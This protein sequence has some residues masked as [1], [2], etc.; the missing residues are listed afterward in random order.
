M[1]DFF[2]IKIPINKEIEKQHRND[3]YTYA[4][5][6]KKNERKLMSLITHGKTELIN[7][8]SLYKLK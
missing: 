7:Y 3:L 4:L 5:T 8:L 6:G 2:D 1:R